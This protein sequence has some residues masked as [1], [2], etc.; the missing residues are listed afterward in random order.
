MHH[1]RF[2]NSDIV[3]A[4]ELD[5]KTHFWNVTDGAEAQASAAQNTFSFA[6][7]ASKKQ[8]VGRHVTTARGDLVLVHAIDGNPGT[9]DARDVT[10]DTGTGTDTDTNT[11]T[12]KDSAPVACFRAPDTINVIECTGEK[13]TVGCQNGHVLHL[14]A[15]FLTQGAGANDR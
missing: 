13:I 2:L 4:Q 9:Q 3:V 12:A 1:V 8:Q 6:E 10:P 14:R 7:G 11:D 5:Y 15:A